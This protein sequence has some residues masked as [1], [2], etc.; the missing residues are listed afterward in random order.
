MA[1]YPELS[2][3]VAIIS[4]APGNLG[5]AVVRRLH[6]DNVKL[7]FMDRN[8]QRLKDLAQQVDSSAVIGV[9]DQTNI[10]RSGGGD[11]WQGRYI[12]E[13]DGRL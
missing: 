13:H 8:E 7:A 1:T 9:V 2:G 12:G 10:C 4:G 11:V 3:K 6:A 5:A